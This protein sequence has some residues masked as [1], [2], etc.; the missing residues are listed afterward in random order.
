[1]H[2]RRSLLAG[3][4]ANATG[5]TR[6][7]VELGFASL[8]REASDADLASLVDA[9][10]DASHVRVVLSA[11]V[12]VCPLRALA[13]ARSAAPR[14]TVR[15]SS[16][17]PVLS[18]A[19]VEETRDDAIVL[20]EERD[21]APV[22]AGEIHVYGTSETIAAVRACARVTVRGHGPGM[23]IAV[24]SAAAGEKGAAES[25][26][27]D[28]VPFD[29]RGC[30]S[31]R[32][33]FVEGGSERAFA[34]AAFLHESLLGW[35]ERVPRG[36]LSR[37]ERADAVK[38]RDALAFAGRVLRGEGHAVAIAPDRAVPPP[39][40]AGRHV[41]VV[42]APT[43]EAIFARA[44]I[45]AP[46]IVAVGSDDPA[47]IAPFAPPHARTSLLGRMQHPPLDGPVDRR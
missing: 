15:P 46:F 36:L 41:L 26:A 18:R 8:E 5:L 37:D 31:P 38:W 33:A 45:F 6:E 23:G 34:F 44:A 35:S 40:A 32:I 25:L 24:V 42:A 7:G 29:Q 28:V 17:D 13:L 14:V 11:N 10:G 3:D 21:V 9:A 30:L 1:M 2:A 4:I 12:F 39:P 20:V 22:E 43:I 16:R 27:S 47:R 19:L